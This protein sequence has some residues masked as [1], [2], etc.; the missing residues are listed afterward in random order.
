MIIITVLFT[1]NVPARDVTFPDHLIATLLMITYN[2]QFVFIANY[3]ILIVRLL[4][5]VAKFFV[6]SSFMV[7]LHHKVHYYIN[8]I[9]IISLIL[10]VL[11]VPTVNEKNS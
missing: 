6:L 4:A 3:I 9:F 1:I 5:L 11:A 7:C 10:T 2:I 8:S